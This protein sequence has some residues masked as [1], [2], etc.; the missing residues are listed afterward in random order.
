MNKITTHTRSE[1][2]I[3]TPKTWISSTLSRHGIYRADTRLIPT[4]G[5]KIQFLTISNCTYRGHRSKFFSRDEREP[6]IES[7]STAR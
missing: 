7:C 1:T 4:F 5:A 3:G 6:E 2:S